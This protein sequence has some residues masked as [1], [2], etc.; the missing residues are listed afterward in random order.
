MSGK[1]DFLLSNPL[2]MVLL[3]IIAICVFLFF[4][5]CWRNIHNPEWE[6]LPEYFFLLTY[7]NISKAA[8]NGNKIDK[9]AYMLNLDN[10][11]MLKYAKTFLSEEYITILER[12]IKQANL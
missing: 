7:I 11:K 6:I 8:S 4:L 3:G 5:Q 1:I 2:T 12:I 9:L 10:N